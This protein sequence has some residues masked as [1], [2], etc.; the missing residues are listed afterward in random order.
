MGNLKETRPHGY[1]CFERY[2]LRYVDKCNLA[3]LKTAWEKQAQKLKLL[4]NLMIKRTA[5]YQTME[6]NLH[7]A[8]AYYHYSIYE[9]KDKR[10]EYPKEID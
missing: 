1:L 7:A 2:A 4:S 3:L 10:L 5:S 9:I 6:N 8:A